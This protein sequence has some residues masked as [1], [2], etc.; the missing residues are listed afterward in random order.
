MP[1][2]RQ[3]LAVLGASG[4]S[5]IGAAAAGTVTVPEVSPAWRAWQAPVSRPNRE[6]AGTTDRVFAVRGEVLYVLS[7]DD[8]SRVAES[9]LRS[10]ATYTNVGVVVG[11]GLCYTGDRALEAFTH[12]GDPRWM[13]SPA[14]NRSLRSTPAVV[15]DTVVAGFPNLVL[16]VSPDGD[17]LWEA[18]VSGDPVDVAAAG[19]RVYVR[20]ESTADDED[21]LVA[22]DRTTGAVRWEHERYPDATGRMAAGRDVLVLPG[23][24]VIALEATDGTERWR[25]RDDRLRSALVDGGTVVAVGGSAEDEPFAERSSTSGVVRAF[26]ITTGEP[27]WET[28]LRGLAFWPPTPAGDGYLVVDNST[29]G[30]QALGPDGDR[31]W[32]VDLNLPPRNGLG[33]ISYPVPGDPHVVAAD[34]SIVGVAERRF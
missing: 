33:P 10:V 8:G 12:G 24:D 5:G 18:E 6:L 19:E 30:L 25:H 23:K 7:R 29:H 13:I 28:S 1:S 15:A 21:R 26:E 11:H 9:E 2:R 32:W 14:G 3:V 16:G 20:T 4:A 22:L 17:R 31:R 34:Q 27:M